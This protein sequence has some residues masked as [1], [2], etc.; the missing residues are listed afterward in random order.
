ME[1]QPLRSNDDGQ[2][3]YTTGK[4]DL[5]NRPSNGKLS[6]DDDKF[7]CNICLDSVKDP[8]VTVCG[9]LYCWPCL[10]RWL[11]TSHTTC[12]VCKAGVTKDNVIPLYIRGSEQDPRTKLN[13]NSGVPNRPNA[14][15]PEPHTPSHTGIPGT[16][17][18]PHNPFS[19]PNGTGTAQIAGLSFS[20]SGFGF[21]PSLFGLQFQSFVPPPQTS[22]GREPSRE[23]EQQTKVSRILVIIGIFAI[24]CL[25]LF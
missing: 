5:P 14:R 12:P 25:L 2:P 13:E 17:L 21:F 4:T 23:E 15:R 3:P 6:G 7:V 8:V 24:V 9:H 11:S 19:G 18:P 1:K 20:A 16:G 10:F 22:T